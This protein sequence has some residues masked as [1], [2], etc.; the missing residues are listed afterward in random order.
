MHLQIMIDNVDTNIYIVVQV[1]AKAGSLHVHA[2]FGTRES[3]CACL[4][5]LFYRTVR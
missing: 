1:S 4:A 2:K 5:V 3:S